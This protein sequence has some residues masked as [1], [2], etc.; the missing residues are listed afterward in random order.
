[1][2]AFLSQSDPKSLTV[3]AIVALWTVFWKGLALWQASRRDQR[4]WFVVL[5]V[6]S[7]LGILEIIYLFFVIKMKPS[8]LFGT[9]NKE[10]TEI[11]K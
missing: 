2:D 8:E 5:L 4:I 10:K 7:T 3:F 11:E 1:M 9:G 6:V